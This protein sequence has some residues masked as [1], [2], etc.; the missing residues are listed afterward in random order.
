M[1]KPSLYSLITIFISAIESAVEIRF[2]C[3]MFLRGDVN[4]ADYQGMTALHHAALRGHIGV[5]SYL[6]HWGC[7]VYAMD[8]DYHSALDLAALYDRHEIVR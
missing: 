2:A 8:N 3:T 7:N 6:V 5:V 4:K 1:S